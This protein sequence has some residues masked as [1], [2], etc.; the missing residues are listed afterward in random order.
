LCRHHV[1]FS[2]PLPSQLPVPL[3]AVGGLS[4]SFYNLPPPSRLSTALA[5]W[6]LTLI[7]TLAYFTFLHRRF[8]G[9]V[10]SDSSN[11]K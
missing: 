4:L 5:W 6:P 2:P 9:K 3:F 7:L 1:T 8:S 10:A 11:S